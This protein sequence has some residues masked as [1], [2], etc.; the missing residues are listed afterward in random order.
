MPFTETNDSVFFFLLRIAN[1]KKQSSFDRM[2]ADRIKNIAALADEK[3]STN[4]EA[5]N[6][7]VCF[8]ERTILVAEIVR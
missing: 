7:I 2:V 1:K 3:K 5:L 6:S 8:C 4:L